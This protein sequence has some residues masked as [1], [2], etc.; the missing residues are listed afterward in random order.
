MHRHVRRKTH[1]GAWRVG[2]RWK[3]P[4]VQ[5]EEGTAEVGVRRGE[6][7]ARHER[8]AASQA[9][10][11]CGGAAG[12]GEAHRAS[13]AVDRQSYK[14][15]RQPPSFGS[16]R[17]RSA[18][19]ARSAHARRTHGACVEG[20]RR[21][22]VEPP[23]RHPVGQGASRAA[24]R[25]MHVPPRAFRGRASR[26]IHVERHTRARCCRSAGGTARS[27][28]RAWGWCDPEWCT[29]SATGSSR[30]TRARSA[31][32]V[33]DDGL[34]MR[35]VSQPSAISSLGAHV[36]QQLGLAAQPV[37]RAVRRRPPPQHRQASDGRQRRGARRRA[38]WGT[39]AATRALLPLG[40][41]LSGTDLRLAHAGSKSSMQRM[42]MALNTT[43]HRHIQ[44]LGERER[45]MSWAA[46]GS[47]IPFTT[48]PHRLIPKDRRVQEF[49]KFIQKIFLGPRALFHPWRETKIQ[50]I[51]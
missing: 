50:E 42:Q 16:P 21:W 22:C 27:G 30:P 40:A 38:G 46:A 4:V 31:A 49:R 23:A 15:D 25:L 13:R 39:S 6:A 24:L 34:G 10:A 43:I 41:R 28:P 11:V 12:A 35:N 20:R 26:A 44:T 48:S 17:A 29:H 47:S 5:T 1:S 45:E 9:A 19:S 7:A 14:I 37:R 2:K 33:H 32:L 51:F 3:E 18:R 36:A 8:V